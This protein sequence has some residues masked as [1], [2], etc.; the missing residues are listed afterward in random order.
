VAGMLMQLVISEV[1]SRR[2][3]WDTKQQLAA[4]NIGKKQVNIFFFQIFSLSVTCTTRLHENNSEIFNFTI[5]ICFLYFN[6][7]IP[8]ATRF[9]EK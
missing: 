3:L 7:S 9:S 5:N 4:E 8:G 1:K 2:N 6:I